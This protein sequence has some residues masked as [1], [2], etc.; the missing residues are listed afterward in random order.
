MGHN[1]FLLGGNSGSFETVKDAIIS[2]ENS[3][4]IFVKR[5]RQSDYRQA[6]VVSQDAM[7]CFEYIVGEILRACERDRSEATYVGSA[8]QATMSALIGKMVRPVTDGEQEAVCTA[9]VGRGELPVGKR[10]QQ[11]TLEVTLNKIK[12]RHPKLMNFRIEQDRHMLVI[13]P[14]KPKGGGADSI[15]EFDVEVF[16][17]ACSAAVPHL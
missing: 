12:H 15:V 14:L 2:L 7:K 13:C 5:W 10:V 4:T 9:G 1:E 8:L 17:N 11:I 3:S 16:C 6:A